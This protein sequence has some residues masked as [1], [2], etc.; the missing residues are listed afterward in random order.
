M[1]FIVKGEGN[2]ELSW[3]HHSYYWRIV[4]YLC[5]C[6]TV[7][8]VRKQGYCLRG[9]GEKFQEVQRRY[10][11]L[12]VRICDQ[13]TNRSQL[14]H[15]SIICLIQP[16]LKMQ[17]ITPFIAYKISGEP[18]ALFAAASIG[19]GISQSHLRDVMFARFKCEPVK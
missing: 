17:F 11:E 4:G 5:F 14:A 12:H 9:P 15:L 19:V 10:P 16:Y 18:V 2:Y 3:K 8:E 1:K 7:L 6:R 13:P